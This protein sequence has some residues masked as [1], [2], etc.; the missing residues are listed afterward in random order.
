MRWAFC[1]P[2]CKCF[3]TCESGCMYF[4]CCT[5]EGYQMSGIGNRLDELPCGWRPIRGHV[6][7]IGSARKF[8]FRS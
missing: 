8:S 3:V 4:F 7:H 6:V 2:S 1:C 5:A